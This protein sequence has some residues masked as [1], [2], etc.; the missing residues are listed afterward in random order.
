[1]RVRGA[2]KRC[3][4]VQSAVATPLIYDMLPRHFD[5]AMPLPSHDAF[6]LLLLMPPASSPDAVTPDDAAIAA[7]AADFAYAAADCRR[8]CCRRHYA[9]CHAAMPFCLICL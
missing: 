1:V 6:V 7:T 2:V 8:H 5:A 9:V 3:V 4:V